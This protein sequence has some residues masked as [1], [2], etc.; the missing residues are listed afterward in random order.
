M[1]EFIFTG[2]E[3]ELLR[4]FR[5][6]RVPSAKSVV[7]VKKFT[8]KRTLD[9]NAQ[10]HVWYTQISKIL[11]D[12]NVQGWERYCK[13]NH[14]VPILRADDQQYR[15][16]YDKAIRSNFSYE[17]KLKI[18]D[19]TPVTRLMNTEQ[20]NRYFEALQNDFMDKGVELRF[21]R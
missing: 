5:S 20:F 2:D 21:L 4:W 14:G 1:A 16:F 15:E 9:Q 13:L 19:Y 17:D 12:D 11:T 10:A 7:T 18:M 6:V 8:K 3:G